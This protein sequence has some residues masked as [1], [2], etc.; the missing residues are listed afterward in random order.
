MLT[1]RNRT[2]A[3]DRPRR[4]RGRPRARHGDRAVLAGEIT[5]NGT[6]QGRQRPL[7]LRLLGPGGPAVVHRRQR[8]GPPG[9]PRQGRPGHAQNWGQID[10]A[11]RAFLTSIGMN[12]GI[13]CNPNKTHFGEGVAEAPP[14]PVRPCG[15]RGFFVSGSRLSGRQ[16]RRRPPTPPAA[17]A[18][19]ATQAAISARRVKPSLARMCST[20]APTV[21]GDRPQRLADRPVGQAVGDEP[22]DLELPRRQRPPRLLFDAAA[23]G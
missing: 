22:G 3:P 15:G 6:P 13:A 8:H 18:I 1:T 2:I 17:T 20:W 21:R 23:R 10:Q 14:A 9:E 5:G 7:L 16:L 11:T 19:V 4:G 12:P